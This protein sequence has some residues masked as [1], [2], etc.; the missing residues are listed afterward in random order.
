MGEGEQEER[1]RNRSVVW[2][3]RVRE[4]SVRSYRDK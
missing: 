1:R 4:C 2:R 3:V